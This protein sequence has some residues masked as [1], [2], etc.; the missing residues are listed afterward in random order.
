MPT[1]PFLVNVEP[2]AEDGGYV[3]ATPMLAGV[4][5][6]GDTKRQAIE[7]LEAALEFTLEDMINNGEPLPEAD[8]FAK[9]PAAGDEDTYE[10]R[11]AV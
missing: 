7:D 6:Q 10:I 1:I 3:A 4:Y 9:P 5:G 11:V 8:S 2:D